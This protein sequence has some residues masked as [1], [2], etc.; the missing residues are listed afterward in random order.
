MLTSLPFLILPAVYLQLP[1][2]TEL[3]YAGT[4]SQITSTG[5]NPL[6]S[7]TC[8]ILIVAGEAGQPELIYQVEERG[9]GGF[10][11]PERFG[12]VVV[13]G[14]HTLRVLQT[15]EGQDYALPLRHPVFEFTEHLRP[16]AQWN[17]GSHQYVCVRS[18]PSRGRECWLVE[19]TLDRGR[20]QT[21]HID[22]QTGLLV[23]L[24]ER[25]FLGRG[26]PF[27]LTLQLDSTRTLDPAEIE[28]NTAAALL[29]LNL[30]R[31]LDRGEEPRTSELTASQV[32]QVETALPRLKQAAANTSWVRLVET[33][34]R[35]LQQQKR[36][37]E[38]LEGLSQK[39][40]G[41]TVPLRD[42]T[43]L[44]GQTWKAAEAREQV[45][46]LHFWDYAGDKLQEPYGQ[47]GYLDF[48]HHRRHKLGVKILGIAVDERFKD[49]ALRGTV[50]RSVRKLQEF[51]NLSYPIALDD[52]SLLKEF[53]DPRALGAS[54]PLWIVIGH[55]GK[56]THYHAGYYQIQPDEGLK[57]LD[58]A[59]VQALKQRAQSD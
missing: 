26:D 46:V 1:V 53:G 36:R 49:P 9:G 32:A 11:W 3:H 57:P 16:E 50:L 35:D 31:D 20:R 7:F 37:L 33:I 47:V 41:Q 40:L 27:T 45:L 6:K 13:S 58:D 34:E 14:K 38:G 22:Q 55:D 17:V 18:M 56:I 48:L 21:L 51:M 52:G 59:V 28:R 54:L 44:T 12:R 2:G 23:F 10:A 30:Q 15:F 8:T 19:A 4:V 39:Y 42:L 24:E 43:L 25:F 5:R 29:L